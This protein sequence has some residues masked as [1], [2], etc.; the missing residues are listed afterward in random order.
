M[1][2]ESYANFR[3]IFT[4]HCTQYRKSDYSRFDVRGTHAAERFFVYGQLSTLVAPVRQTWASNSIERKQH[5]RVPATT[6]EAITVVSSAHKL[7]ERTRKINTIT[8][9]T[10]SVA[11]AKRN[12][13]RPGSLWVNR[14]SLGASFPGHRYP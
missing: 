14:P 7:V 11:R 8:Q 9:A 13:W 1:L 3:G 10:Q 5:L 4:L 2:H 12:A 6:L